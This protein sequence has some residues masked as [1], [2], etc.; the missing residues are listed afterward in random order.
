MD[1][2][3][4]IDDPVV[5]FTN[6]RDN[7]TFAR[8]S[9]GAESEVLGEDERLRIINEIFGSPGLAAFG[10]VD[11]NPAKA[12]C[13]CDV[14]QCQENKPQKGHEGSCEKAQCSTGDGKVTRT[15]SG[16][17]VLSRRK[18]NPFYC[19][20]RQITELVSK[21]RKAKGPNLLKSQSS[22]AILTLNQIQGERKANKRSGA[23]SSR[24]SRP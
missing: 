2:I 10:N 12:D 3:D 13:D 23:G 9:A 16:M 4:S 15:G 8:C 19:P 7:E 24:T 20:S 21:R 6:D 22:V 5:F 18:S 14:N 17:P 1:F 11:L